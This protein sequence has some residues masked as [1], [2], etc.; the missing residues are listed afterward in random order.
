MRAE[1]ERAQERADAAISVAGADVAL[2]K[3]RSL[4]KRK[5]MIVHNHAV[6]GSLPRREGF[7]LRLEAIDER[8]IHADPATP[9]LH[10]KANTI[11]SGKV[12]DD[13]TLSP[14]PRI[15]EALEHCEAV[16]IMIFETRRRSC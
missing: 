3:F 14:S 12:E 5:S 2:I 4:S 9:H 16:L 7:Y 6:V 10:H 15:G 8:T 1:Q 11:G 13:P